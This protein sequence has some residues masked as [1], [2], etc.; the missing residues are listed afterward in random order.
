MNIIIAFSNWV[1][2][3][4]VVLG[5]LVQVTIALLVAFGVALN[6]A[7]IAAINAFAAVL[8]GVI[9]RSNVT[10]TFKLG[11]SSAP[12]R[13][14]A[15]TLSQPAPTVPAQPKPSPAQPPGDAHP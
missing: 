13:Q 2:S 15:N 14:G 4:L 6:P 7:Q 9:A 11:I 8:L 3:E 12:N 5:S 1:R 10:P